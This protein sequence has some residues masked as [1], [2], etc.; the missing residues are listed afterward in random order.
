MVFSRWGGVEPVGEHVRD[1]VLFVD[2]LLL[3]EIE[4]GSVGGVLTD[5]AIA[6][7]EGLKQHYPD[8]EL[9]VVIGQIRTGTVTFGS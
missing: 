1:V 3:V 5:E 6:T 2:S 7:L 4:G 8:Q 9:T